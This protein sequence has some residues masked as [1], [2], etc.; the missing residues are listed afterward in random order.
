MRNLKAST[1]IETEYSNETD[2]IN[3]SA[4]LSNKLNPIESILLKQT[5]V[6][7]NTKHMVY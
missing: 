7:D 4:M 3:N 6:T 2:N 5:T 1:G